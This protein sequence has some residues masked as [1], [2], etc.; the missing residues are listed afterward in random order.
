MRHYNGLEK[1][2]SSTQAK[3]ETGGWRAFQEIYAFVRIKVHCYKDI[4]ALK[5]FNAVFLIHAVIEY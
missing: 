3:E 1:T 5:R 2:F 4:M